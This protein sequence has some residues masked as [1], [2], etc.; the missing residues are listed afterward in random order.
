MVCG[1]IV[2]TCVTWLFWEEM[3]VCSVFA[4]TVLVSHIKTLF[5]QNTMKH[6][7]HIWKQ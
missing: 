1:V 5:T 3:M 6:K 2:Y 4:C 7:K